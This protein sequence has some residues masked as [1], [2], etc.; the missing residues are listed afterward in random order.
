MT[1]N[2]KKIYCV[3]TVNGMPCGILASWRSG[4]LSIVKVDSFPLGAANYKELI[5]KEA[6]DRVKKGF[7]VFI[8]EGFQVVKVRGAYHI[9]LDSVDELSGNTVVNIAMKQYRAMSS[10]AVIVY[11]DTAS[12]VTIPQSNI[13]EVIDDKG[14]TIFQLYWSEIKPHHRAMLLVVYAVVSNNPSHLPILKSMLASV[15]SSGNQ[16]VALISSR[17]SAFAKHHRQQQRDLVSAQDL[18]DI[19]SSDGIPEGFTYVK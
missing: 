10:S 6:S 3:S 4:Q 13:N 8:E 19:H 1:S 11:G 5:T 7:L 16:V 9:G 14:R 12:N 18:A 15:K 17:S 2:D